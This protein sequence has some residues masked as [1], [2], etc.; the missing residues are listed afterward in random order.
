LYLGQADAVIAELGMRQEFCVQYTHA[1][2]YKSRGLDAC[3]DC[4]EPTIH[5][6]K[7][8]SALM[9]KLNSR[10]SRFKPERVTRYVTDWK[11][12]DE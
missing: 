7:S 6:Q 2:R 5:D 1:P 11:E 9:E 3:D 4:S 8:A 12:D 10:G